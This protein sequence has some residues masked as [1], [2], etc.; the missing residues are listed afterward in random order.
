MYYHVI[1]CQ[2]LI[3]YSISVH[4]CTIEGYEQALQTIQVASPHPV[5]LLQNVPKAFLSWPI[6]TDMQKLCK[7]YSYG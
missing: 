1:H 5:R 3:K 2:G 6:L 7:H 4:V